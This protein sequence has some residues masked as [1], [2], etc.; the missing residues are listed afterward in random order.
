V[1]TLCRPAHCALGE[2]SHPIKGEWRQLSLERPRHFIESKR[3]A[4]QELD[5]A[6]ARWIA[7]LNGPSLNHAI[8]RRLKTQSTHWLWHHEKKIT[9]LTRA[10]NEAEL[11]LDAVDNETSLFPM[12]AMQSS[13]E[14]WILAG[15]TVKLQSAE[16]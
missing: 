6:S 8:W 4:G 13:T 12:S 14:P 11:E 5:A 3:W 9:P 2:K 1:T 10:F 7:C 16:P 15:M